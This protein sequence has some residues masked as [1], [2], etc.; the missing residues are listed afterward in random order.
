MLD[1]VRESPAGLLLNWAS[2]GRILPFPEQRADYV[3]PAH[4]LSAPPSYPPTPASLRSLPGERS[5]DAATLVD[6]S[7]TVEKALEPNVRVE[8]YPYLVEWAA[9]DP[10]N[11]RNWLFAKKLFV[12][13]QVCL[14]SLVFYIGSSVWTA[15]QPGIMEEYGASTTVATL[16][17]SFGFGP[18][19]LAPLQETPRIGRTSV[20]YST[21]A[22]YMLLQAPILTSDS[23]VCILVFRFLTG[24]V[25]SPA[26]ATG[27]AS[28]GDMCDTLDM[29]YAVGTWS[30]F[31]V[32]GPILGPVIGGF[33]AQAKT[34]KWPLYELL[35]MC[36]FGF[37][38]F[39]FF[40]PETFAA[41]LLLRRAARLRKLTGNHEIKTQAELDARFHPGL[42]KAGAKQVGL[43]FRLCFEPAIAFSDAY[44]GLVYG[45]FYLWFE[46]F[47][48]VFSDYH[49]FN[50]GVA[51]LP[52]L[53]FIVAGIPTFAAY[54]A[55]YKY[56]F[57]PRLVA[58]NFKL[59]PEANLELAFWA[60]PF[61]PLSLLIFGWTGNSPTTSWWGPTVGAALY[62]PGEYG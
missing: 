29:P 24:F 7:G 45:V 58:S 61:I 38:I 52:F 60:S 57:N 6:A 39:T 17:L 40:L 44:T 10:D 47:P 23:L 25:G 53:S 55:Y 56:R 9:E 59:A 33:A 42:L 35:W 22:L 54:V 51:A 13:G 4:F 1:L 32:A 16:G 15:S 34:W 3:P 18:M 19:I 31:A 14:L 48:I 11:P 2:K 49:G 41:T 5:P 28:L 36:G 37:A 30:V 43:A 12:S 8:A 26:I 62:F 27:V 21:M 20:Y 46:A 50:L